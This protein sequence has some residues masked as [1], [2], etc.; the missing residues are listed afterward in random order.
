MTSATI[1]NSN[2]PRKQVSVD[3][4]LKSFVKADLAEAVS[5]LRLSRQMKAYTFR[6]GAVVLAKFLHAEFHPYFNFSCFS[7]ALRL[8]S[9][10]FDCIQRTTLHCIE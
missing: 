1:D 5:L 10:T 8:Y 2:G 7:L 9:A 3:V 6:V 4:V